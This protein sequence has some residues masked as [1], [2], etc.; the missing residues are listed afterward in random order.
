MPSI[1]LTKFSASESLYFMTP[2]VDASAVTPGDTTLNP[3]RAL[4]IG[5]GG[6]LTVQMAADLD[7]EGG[8]TVTFISVATGSILPIS[9]IK[10][11]A[12]T[13]ASSIVALY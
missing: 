5:T 10:V 11:T 9:V 12:A 4:Y 3:T 13:T 6:N 2:A 7:G 1:D 8:E